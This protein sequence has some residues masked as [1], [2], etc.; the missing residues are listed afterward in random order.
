MGVWFG[1][2]FT[3]FPHATAQLQPTI[4][5]LYE[6]FMLPLG[7]ELLPCLSG[8]LSSLLIGL[9]ALEEDETG[10]AT[11]LPAPSCAL[12]VCMCGINLLQ[13]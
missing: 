3:L 7:P 10:T 4:L 9:D 11:T 13:E 8:L 6:R 1:G 5:R 2:L 12:C